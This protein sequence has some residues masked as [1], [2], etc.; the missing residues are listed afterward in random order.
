MMKPGELV[1]AEMVDG[2]C[3]RYHCL[4]SALEQ[5]DSTLLYMLNILA[6]AA[7]NE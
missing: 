4:P 7:P 5:E 1:W 3:R 2:L 6:E